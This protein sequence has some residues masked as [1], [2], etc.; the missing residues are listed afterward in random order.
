MGNQVGPQIVTARNVLQF[1]RADERSFFIVWSDGSVDKICLPASMPSSSSLA[2][3]VAVTAKRIGQQ[4][5][6]KIWNK[7]LTE[8]PPLEVGYI[9]NVAQ[10][11]KKKYEE[12]PDPVTLSQIKSVKFNNEIADIIRTEVYWKSEDSNIDE[13]HARWNPSEKHEYSPVI[14]VCYSIL[15]HINSYTMF[16]SWIDKLSADQC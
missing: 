10:P 2:F 16:G 14:G 15:K 12:D 11:T 3:C 6:R 5:L 7:Y 4:N 8:E 13:S 9:V 1:F